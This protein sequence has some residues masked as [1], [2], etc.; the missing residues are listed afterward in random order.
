MDYTTVTA[1]RKWANYGANKDDT[2]LV[3][4]ISAASRAIDRYCGRRFG[5]DT[6]T[7][8]T[9]TAR[10]IGFDYVTP[11]EGGLLTLDD[12]L[13]EAASSITGSPAVT[14]LDPN[15]PPYYA[16]LLDDG[17]WES[18]ITVTGKWAYSVVPPTDIEL[19]CLRLVKWMYEM[20]ETTRGDAAVVTDVGA[21]LLPAGLPVDVIT[22]LAPYRKLRVSG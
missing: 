22:L 15:E 2:V 4:L 9:F 16:I 20:R 8:H 14:Y 13:A 12:D 11:F 3:A 6:A 18:P 7:A 10:Y 5:A 17:Y 19:A 21:V 1:L